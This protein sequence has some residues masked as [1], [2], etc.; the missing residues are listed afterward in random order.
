MSGAMG[1]LLIFFVMLCATNVVAEDAE[2][3]GDAHYT[4]TGFFDI[5]VC[6]WPDRPPFYMTLYS[7]Y[8]FKDVRLIELMNAEGEKFA[9][10]DLSKFRVITSDGKPEKRVFMNQIAQPEH[11][12]D[13]WFSAKITLNDD[14]VHVAKDF[15]EHGVLSQVVGHWPA[16]R[17]EVADPPEVLHWS[18][19]KGAAHYQVFIKDKWN[20]SEMLFSSD[21]LASP[22]VVLPEG[23]LESGGYYAW[24]VHARDVN[25]DIKLGDFNQGS[26]SD[27][28]EFTV[29]N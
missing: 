3:P 18:V 10:L 20:E 13:G 5:H 7:T 27:W 14:S 1:A 21:L 9:T 19:V 26:L 23:L 25:E 22:E 28:Q 24:R 8:Q 12:I 4:E 15:V 11:S 16:H 2:H 17:S 29:A 6:N